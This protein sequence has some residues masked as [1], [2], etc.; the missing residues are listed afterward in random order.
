MNFRTI[1]AT[2]LSLAAGVLLI[3]TAR[4][5]E[6]KQ[7]P[8]KVQQARDEVTKY[9]VKL[10]GAK[11]PAIQWLDDASLKEVFPALTFFA[12]RYP[13][14]PLAFA[15]PKGLGSSNVFV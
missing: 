4:G 2:A 5:G 6:T 11:Q 3:S 8:A 9:L 14:F 15:P 10:G 12:V 1:A 7:L 13:Q